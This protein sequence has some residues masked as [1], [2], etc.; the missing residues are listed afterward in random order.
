MLVIINENELQNIFVSNNNFHYQSVRIKQ[1]F[2]N[3]GRLNYFY[4]NGK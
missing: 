2:L 1:K 3:K 4:G